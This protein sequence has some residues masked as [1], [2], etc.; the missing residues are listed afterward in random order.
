LADQGGEALT[1]MAV[2]GAAGKLRK[3]QQ[4]V[5]QGWDFG[6]SEAPGRG[7]LGGDLPGTIHLLEGLFGQDAVMAD[8]LD[9]E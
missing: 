9:F 3:G 7:A 2:G 6:I 5:A 4:R 1:P 8:L